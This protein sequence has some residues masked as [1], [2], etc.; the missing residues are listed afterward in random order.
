LNPAHVPE[1]LGN[2]SNCLWL[3]WRHLGLPEPTRR[4][5]EIAE[6]LQEGPDR[7]IVEGFRG[8]GKSWI[9]S[10]FADWSLLVD[11]NINILVVSASKSRAD[12]F[13]IFSKRLIREVEWLQHLCA[14][15]DQRDSNVSWDVGPAPA[16]H[17]PSV[18]SIGIS[19]QITGSRADLIIVD[20]VETSANSLTQVMREKILKST[21]EFESVLKP[22]GRIC[23]LGTP[24][25]EDSIYTHLEKRGYTTR[26]WPA[27]FPGRKLQEFYGPKL[28]PAILAEIEKEPELEGRPTDG[29]RFD[30]FTLL[31]KEGSMGRSTFALQFMLDTSLSDANRY[32]LKLSDL[33]VMDLDKD[34]CP[35]KVVYGRDHERIIRDLP[36]VGLAGDR[37]YAPMSTIGK[38]LPWEG[39][40]LAIDP[41]G[42]GADE[43]A[44]TITKILN[45]QIGLMAWGGFLHGYAEATLQQLALIAKRYK[46]SHCVY[47]ANF[48]DGMFGQLFRPVLGKVH[49]CTV[50]EVKHSIQKEK[51]IIDT[52]EPV[53]CQHKLLIDRAA[54][55][56]D[57]DVDEGVAPESRGSYQLL[58]QLTRITREKGALLHD[59]RL[60][61]LA[62]A[63]AY[64]LEHLGADIDDKMRDQAMEAW[65]REL[66][67]ILDRQ[68]PSKG[69]WLSHTYRWAQTA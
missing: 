35:E 32:P 54:I 6:W 31:E 63:V 52:L 44:W 69:S 59:D 24:H 64:W 51:R 57:S 5:Y 11:P 50:E 16:A 55:E 34:V 25:C 58:Y 2:F 30:D 39:S 53:L 17:A 12:D 42:R 62:I 38:L 43:C 29:D 19:G 60:D 15:E 46:I 20:D 7:L 41:S 48:G 26:I 66:D 56:A 37:F 45:G 9:T 28:S 27:R 33:I 40:L 8:V 49:P 13:S 68:D 36:C 21:E 10:A 3:L 67:D 14:S 47:E 23:Y 65:D 18:K 1:G 61:C 22:G 4:Q